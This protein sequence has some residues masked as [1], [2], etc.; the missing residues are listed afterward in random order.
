M[1][2]ANQGDFKRQIRRDESAASDS[3]RWERDFAALGIAHTRSHVDMHACP[4][5]FQSLRVWAETQQR[6]D[7]I[8]HMSY[9]DRTAARA[10]THFEAVPLRVFEAARGGARVARWA[11]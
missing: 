8:W 3:V 1:E 6:D 4:F 7:E 5:D 2:L 11:A 10:G 9:I